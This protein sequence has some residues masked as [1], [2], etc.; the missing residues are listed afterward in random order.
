MTCDC[1]EFTCSLVLIIYAAG[2]R[3]QNLVAEFLARI[4]PSDVELRRKSKLCLPN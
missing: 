3:I 2:K 4:I 1:F